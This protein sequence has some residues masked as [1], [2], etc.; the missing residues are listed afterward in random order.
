[1]KQIILYCGILLLSLCCSEPSA[2]EPAASPD[3]ADGTA[4]MV[5]E[6]RT[7]AQRTDNLQMWHLNRARA[8]AIDQRL[9]QVSD[10]GQRISMLFQSGIEWLNAGEYQRAIAQLQA[11]FD[12]IDGQQLKLPPQQYWTIKE[13][14][15][16]AHLRKGEIENCLQ[17]HNAYSCILPIEEAGQH[18][19]REGSEN[20]LQIFDEILTAQPSN[21]QVKWLYNLA[22]MTLGG[23]PQDIPAGRLIQPEVF[24]SEAALPRFTDRAME[25]GLAVNDIS[26][27]VVM[28]DF[29]NDH[30]LDLLVSSYG[31]DDQLRYFENDGRG[32]FTDQTEAAGLTGLWSGLNMVQAD[33]NNDGWVDVL[34][35]RGAWLG[36]DGNHPNSLLRNNGD[37][38]FSDVTRHSGLYCQYPTQ[39]AAW[40]DFDADGWID[41]FIANEYSSNTPA[42]AQLF[43]NRGDGTFREVAA[44][45]GVAIRAFVKGCVASDYNNDG[46]ADLYL[47]AISGDN[48]L[49]Q[50]GG[51]A[52]DFKFKNVAAT[53][54]TTEPRVSFPCWFFDY[55]Q[56]GWEDLFVSGFDF[57][58]FETAAG[59]VARDYL[60]EK[61]SA[62]LPRLYHNNQDG[63][64]SEVS[65]AMGVDQV[66]FT[67]GCN[68]GDLNND[69]YPDFY[70]TTGTPDFRALVPNRMFLNGGKGQAFL[71]VTRAG[72]FG[73]LQKGHGV[74]FGDIDADGD[75]DIY[76]VLGGS[77]DGDNFMNALFVNPG[78]A[79]HWV[80]LR[81]VG[82]RSNRSAIGARLRIR[83]SDA[84]G[85]TRDFYSRVN[86]GASFGA[87][88]LL[89]EQGL[90]AYAQIES[91][92]VWWPGQSTAESF[93]GVSSDGY[94][95]IEEG[96][97]MAKKV[98]VPTLQLR[99]DAGHK[100]H[101]Q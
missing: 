60:G 91:V 54:G 71:D 96:K 7:I 45:K 88:P 53:A 93:G 43:H 90:A 94:F 33:Y 17:A 8:Q 73:H 92:D 48:Y 30:Y 76:H 36:T 61:V 51:P 62:E 44:E 14:L 38:T 10:P 85:D 100:H 83:A 22:Q 15:G 63:T 98:D 27:S 29:N 42:T 78:P 68:F 52:E 35:L 32:G 59:E 9:D 11:I 47:S 101:H 2:P 34:V 75:Q 95:F 12:F 65:Q 40:L 81:L 16:I 70:A 21:V 46:F 84:R 3:A 37:G 55:D 4:A 1:M 66:L 74:A 86:S 24:E 26:G 89:V 57:Q 49:L 13:L 69:G 5:A 58:Q 25:L 41:L 77:Y 64:F 6:L 50:N 23:Y 20:A 28:D 82:R 72:G 67:M 18:Q 56:D 19:L 80:K 97:G 39:T 31:L 99:G 87:S 79:Q